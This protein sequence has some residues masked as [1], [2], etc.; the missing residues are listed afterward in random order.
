ML[1]PSH[2]VLFVCLFCRF[3]FSLF[4][5]SSSV[6]FLNIYSGWIFLSVFLCLITQSWSEINCSPNR[7]IT[8]VESIVN[9]KY[10]TYYWL[11]LC[12][13]Q[14]EHILVHTYHFLHFFFLYST[15]F[16]LGFSLSLITISFSTITFFVM[17]YIIIHYRKKWIFFSFDY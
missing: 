2:S 14:H 7:R 17:S 8:I 6:F 11:V 13:C 5:S 12:C 3:F 1:R 9:N 10:L 15:H 16:W 4:Q